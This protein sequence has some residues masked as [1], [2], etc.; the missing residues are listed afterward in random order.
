M[1]DDLNNKERVIKGIL[2]EVQYQPNTDQLWANLEPQLPVKKKRRI[3]PFWWI[4]GLSLLILCSIGLGYALAHMD[5][6]IDRGRELE[7]HYFKK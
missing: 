1:N 7:E 3:L 2:E 5:S 4:S 6:K